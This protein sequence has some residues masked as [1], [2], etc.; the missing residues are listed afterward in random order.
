MSSGVAWKVEDW[1]LE[2]GRLSGYSGRG[3]EI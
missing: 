3:P 2:V 1:G